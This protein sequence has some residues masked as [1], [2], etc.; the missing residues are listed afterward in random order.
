MHKRVIAAVLGAA[1][2]AVPAAAAADSGHARGHDKRT[3]KKVVNDHAKGRK[4]KTVLFVFKGSFSTPDTV[5]VSSGNAHVRRGGF[6]GQAV[7]FDFAS[8]KVVAADTN[9]DG[10]VDLAD[11]KAG[12]LVLVQARMVKGIKY[13]APTEG[14]PAERFVVRRLIDK[15][16]PPIT[17]HEAVPAGEPKKGSPA[18]HAGG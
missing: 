5:K 10:K 18:E 11:V 3:S 1:A 9:A 7:K 4:A 14:E 17:V 15:T 2:L 13:D 12:D 6:A 16:N 8:A